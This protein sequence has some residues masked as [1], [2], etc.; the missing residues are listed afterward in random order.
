MVACKATDVK[1]G[2]HIDRQGQ[3]SNTHTHMIE[4]TL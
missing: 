2:T 1:G 3:L 4:D